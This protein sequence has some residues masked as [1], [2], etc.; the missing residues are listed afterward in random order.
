MKTLIGMMIFVT[1]LDL[2]L[3]GAVYNIGAKL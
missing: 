3:L 2:I 1:T